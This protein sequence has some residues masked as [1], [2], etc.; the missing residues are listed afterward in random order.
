MRSFS[1]S[2]DALY[3]KIGSFRGPHD[4]GRHQGFFV[5]LS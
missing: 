2:F 1:R 4:A 3:A 5:R